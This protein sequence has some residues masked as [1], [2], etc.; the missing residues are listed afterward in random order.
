MKQKFLTL[1][2]CTSMFIFAGCSTDE[3][4]NN[5]ET[6]DKIEEN[7]QNEQNNEIEEEK[8]VLDTIE[9]D[10]SVEVLVNR[11]HS[12]SEDYIPEDL[13]R[14][15]V[16]TVLEDEEVNQLREVAANALAEMFEDAEEEGIKLYARSGY[17]SYQTQV[18]LFNNYAAQYGEEEANK[19]SAKPGE[20]E[21][22]TGLV[23][24][25][26]AQSVDL[27]LSEELG[28]TDEGIWLAENAHKYGFIIRYPEDKEEITKYI[29]EPWHIRY[30][31]VDLA[32][33][34]YNSGLSYEEFV[35]EEGILEDVKP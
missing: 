4:G 24:D 27:Q 23:M 30:L 6:N 33:L 20:S 14:V 3:N 15:S 2:T 12:L 29:Y 13:V 11:E 22:Q 8:N 5:V 28:K 34:V 17:R 31:G 21:H 18:S 16:D 32:T 35:E 10:P 1:L 7:E 26:T 25:V 9:H 19:F